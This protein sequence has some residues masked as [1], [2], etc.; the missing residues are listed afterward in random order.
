MHF[1]G[2]AD[3]GIRQRQLKIVIICVFRSVGFAANF[4]QELTILAQCLLN[5]VFYHL[6]VKILN[7]LFGK[8]VGTI[9]NPG[10]FIGFADFQRFD[11]HFKT[12]TGDATLNR[13]FY[14]FPDGFHS[15]L[16]F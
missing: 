8:K 12:M 2:W 15:C 3:Y 14:F 7:P 5:G 6:A 4:K 16:L 11:P 13:R 9:D 10:S 1:A